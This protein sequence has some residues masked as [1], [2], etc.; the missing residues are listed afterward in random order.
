MNWF[1]AVEL[2]Q[3]TA[4]AVADLVGRFDDIGRYAVEAAD[5]LHI[6]LCFYGSVTTAAVGPLELAVSGV[7]AS[8]TPF[9]LAVE[10]GGTFP[11]ARVAWAGV[12]GDL[13]ALGRLRRSLCDASAHLGGTSRSEEAQ[14]RP[15]A[16]HVTVARWR[17][18]RL[19]PAPL[20]DHLLTT[21]CSAPFVVDRVTLL[22]SG[23]G[24]FRVRSVHRLG[25]PT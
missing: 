25:V 6:T 16:P 13:E 12:A 18:R 11:G 23:G 22:T 8:A 2:P 1:A 14:S 10:G 4:N 17:D 19:D 9:P 20:V 5:R 24:R 3:A 21:V 7:A 15:Y